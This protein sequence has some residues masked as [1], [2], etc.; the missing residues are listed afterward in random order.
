MQTCLNLRLL[1][2]Q[3]FIKIKSPLES[4][5][6]F[7]PAI[8]HH[9]QNASF[10]QLSLNIS[11]SVFLGRSIFTIWIIKTVFHLLR[12]ISAYL[13]SLCWHNSLSSSNKRA[14]L[15]RNHSAHIKAARSLC[16]MKIVVKERERLTCVNTRL[17]YV[18]YPRR[19]T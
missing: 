1:D 6:V 19:L 14:C 9:M 18:I 13:S 10:P 12:Q 17:K 7:I 11:H 5:S 15:K 8:H 2:C 16:Q 3:H 4:N